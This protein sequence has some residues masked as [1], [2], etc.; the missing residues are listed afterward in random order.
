LHI[1]WRKVQLIPL[2]K[3]PDIDHVRRRLS[4]TSP[5]WKAAKIGLTA[6]YL[7]IQVGPGVSDDF[8]FA[9]P[10]EKYISRCRFIARLG[11][12][13]ARAAAMHNLFA[14]PVLSYVAQVQGDA[15][16][17]EQVLDRASAILFRTPMYRPPHRFFVHLAMLGIGTG[18]KDV[19]MECRAAAARCSLSLSALGLARR[20][21]ATGSDDDHLRVHTHREWQNRCAVQRLGLWRDRLSR[22]LSPLPVPPFLQRQCRAHL[23]AHRPALDYFE[24]IQA[25]LLPVLRRLGEDALRDL[26]TLAGDL[27]D[28]ILLASVNLHCSVM[29]A[30]LRFSQN[31]LLLGR[32]GSG[33]A[34]PFC[35]ALAAFR[36]SH[37]LTCGGVWVFIDEHCPGSGLDCSHPRRWSFLF[38]TG[39]DNSDRA[40][41]ICLIWDAIFAGILAGR[42]AGDAFAGAVARIIAVSKR[43]GVTGRLA[44]A[45]MTPP[46]AV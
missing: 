28:L 30:V 2:W 37:I 33:A 39:T 22:E 29:Q 10:L 35:G 18:L 25:R 7:G 11:L 14:L 21:L 6:K 40:S 27:L 38:G 45:M 32:G 9:A 42:F 1:H 13:W 16:I 43:P 23:L 26:H 19:R 36:L 46:S 24:L 41:M 8:A 4:A 3:E 44:I 15:G 12:G 31:G 5:R 34:C 20:Q 17:K